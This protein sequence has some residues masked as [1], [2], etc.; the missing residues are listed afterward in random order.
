MHYSF[1]SLS[2]RF[3]SAF[4]WFFTLVMLLLYLIELHAVITAKLSP[5][6]LIG[7]VNLLDFINDP[8]V[9]FGLAN[10][11]CQARMDSLDGNTLEVRKNL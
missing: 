5:I 9:D 11:D 4:W 3:L 10:G 2:T 6:S 7:D 1:Q 8:D